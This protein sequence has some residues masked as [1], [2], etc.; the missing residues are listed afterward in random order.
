MAKYVHDLKHA[1]N[2][3]KGIKARVRVRIRVKVKVK[4]GVRVRGRV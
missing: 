3:V 1:F 4:V 2:R